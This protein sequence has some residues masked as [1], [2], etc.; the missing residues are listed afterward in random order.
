MSRSQRVKQAHA[1]SDYDETIQEIINRTREKCFFCPENLEK[2]TPKFPP[3]IAPEGRLRKGNFVLLPNLFPFA[4]HHAVGV[5]SENH[6][7]RLNEITKETLENS[8]AVSIDHFNR[9]FKLNNEMKFCSINMNYMPPAGASIVH[10]HTQITSDIK[11]SGKLLELLQKSQEYH[12][13]HGT[14]YWTDLVETEAWLKERFIGTSGD[15]SWLTNY[16]PMGKNEVLGIVTSP[17]SH[18]RAFDEVLIRDFSEGLSKI[19]KGLWEKRHVRSIN[20]TIYSGPIDTNL[21]DYFRVH[22]KMISRPVLRPFY[23]SDT[24]FMENFYA[25][26]IIETAPEDVASDLRSMW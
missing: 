11:G 1:P 24:A 4:E 8:F 25:E 9:I 23:T 14:N 2:T 12:K 10:P 18:F 16:A 3:E 26:P 22:I 19:F 13:I 21:S 15:V 6:F 5:L 20:F 17:I 7:L